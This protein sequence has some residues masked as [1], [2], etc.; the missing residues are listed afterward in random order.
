MNKIKSMF[1]I[2]L[3]LVIIFGCV[4]ISSSIDWKQFSG[5]ELKVLSVDQP[6]QRGIRERFEQFKK[7][8]GIKVSMDI[9]PWT[10]LEQVINTEFATKSSNYDIVFA[11]TSHLRPYATAGWIE[12]LDRYINDKTITDSD[13]LNIED[14]FPD[15]LEAL[16][17]NE[18][19]YS[20]PFFYASQMLF[21]R[22]DIFEKA[23]IDS[24]PDTFAELME[25]A[26]KIDSEEIPAITLRARAGNTFNMWTFL[27][28][29]YGMGGN[30]FVNY[31]D[32]LCPDL[33]S[34]EVI[35]AVKTYSTLLQ[36]YGPKDYG[37]LGFPDNIANFQTGQV[38]M[39]I[40][41]ITTAGN[42][43]DPSKS[44]VRG[45]TGFA[46][47]PKGDAGRFPPFA[48]QGWTINTFSNNKKAAWILMQWMTCEEVVTDIAVEK[49]FPAVTRM[50]ILNNEEYA[51]KYD[52]FWGG[53]KSYLDIYRETTKYANPNFMPPVP[54]Y[55][56]LGDLAGQ[57]L[58]EVII[59]EKD[60]EKAFTKLN[61]TLI[62]EMKKAGYDIK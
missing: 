35:E 39:T 17:L 42:I 47:L 11:H 40:E 23:G 26:K 50:S 2:L 46:L 15:I 7:E 33:E 48:A 58:N 51:K 41:G 55:T 16:R 14:F 3:S 25:V 37:S 59:G 31:P 56:K 34:P 21:Y 12:P 24:P 6:Y 30:F 60:A 18:Q 5:T 20:L 61:D 49:N 62:Q 54:E 53:E 29:M 4:G 36:E 10:S 44:K 43:L 52:H 57:A 9:V 27:S 19:L 13:V 32:N 38:A 1:I 8:T 28:F 22:L 45:K